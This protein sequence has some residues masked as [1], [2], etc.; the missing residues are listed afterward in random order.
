MVSKHRAVVLSNGP[1]GKTVGKDGLNFIV[2]RKFKNLNLTEYIPPRL[3]KTKKTNHSLSF[4]H[5][6]LFF[7]SDTAR[8]NGRLF[9]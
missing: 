5:D 8:R 3:R 4:E 9:Q 1:P 2:T 6:Q 7:Y